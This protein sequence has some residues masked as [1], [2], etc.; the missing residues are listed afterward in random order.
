[1]AKPSTAP[2]EV[3][4]FALNHLRRQRKIRPMK[5]SYDCSLIDID[6]LFSEPGTK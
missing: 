4:F 3:A 1:M 5:I 2:L 6:A